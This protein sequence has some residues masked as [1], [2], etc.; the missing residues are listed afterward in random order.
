MEQIWAIVERMQGDIAVEIRQ[1]L[2]ETVLSHELFSD[3]QR[4][5]R[6]QAMKMCAADSLSE[7]ERHLQWVEMHREAGW[8]Y[9]PLFD[10][11]TKQ[12]P[13]MVPWSELPAESRYKA[14]I[15]CI[16]AKAARAIEIE[17]LKAD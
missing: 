13:N 10:P 7:E 12:H 15:F 6:I 14:R 8:V 9:G 4:A 3:E 17:S 11:K 16:V 5:R 2:G 1:M